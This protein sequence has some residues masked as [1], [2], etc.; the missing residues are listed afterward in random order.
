MDALAGPRDAADWRATRARGDALTIWRVARPPEEGGYPGLRPGVELVDAMRVERDVAVPVRDGTRLRVDLFLPDAH[1]S[2]LPALIAWGP[3][4][5]H[6]PLRCKDIAGSG[7]EAAWVSD[8][9]SFEGPDPVYWTRH[10]YALVHVDPRGTWGSEGDC[11]FHDPREAL[12]CYDVIEW[13]AS[14]PWCS[15]QVGMTGVSYLAIVQWYVAALHPPHLAAINPWEGFT[16]LYRD[17]T[18]H[19]GIPE[20]GFSTLW[21]ASRVGYGTGRVEDLVAEAA[22]HPLFDDYW[23]YKVP[24]LSS[25]DVPAYVVAGWGDHGLHTRGTIE[26]F[27]AIA[28]EYK[29]LEIHGQQ[30]WGYYYEPASV[31]RQRQFFDRFLLGRETEVSSW[32]RVRFEVRTGSGTVG[33]LLARESWPPEDVEQRTLYLDAARGRL[34]EALPPQE[35]DVAYEAVDSTGAVFEHVFTEDTDVVGTVACTIWLECRGSDDADV[36]VA[37]QKLDAG[38]ERVGFPFYTTFYDGDVALGWLR[39]SHR[40]NAEGDEA[41]EVLRHER[42]HELLAG[43]AV[44]VT[45]EVWPTATRFRA[46]ETLRLV[47]KGRDTFAYGPEARVMAH[48]SY[49][50]GTH[51]IRTGGRYPSRLTLPV[52]IGGR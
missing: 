16:D 37:L 28:S 14:Q 48:G 12:D 32:P 1:S 19:G 23:R 38:G 46:G 47:L 9:A 36:F 8:H 43:R 20:V 33:P 35:A 44:P 29:W 5:K 11:V 26:G 15:G 40:A 41:L 31:E 24:D 13:L 50:V 3:Y 42:R 10:G 18:F 25:I 30:K 51:V 34:A 27:R 4:G 17:Y 21:L 39:A 6:S 22:A 45:V 2:P 7:V 49:R 52:L